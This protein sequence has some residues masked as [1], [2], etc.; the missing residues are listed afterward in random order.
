MLTFEELNGIVINT[1]LPKGQAKRHFSDIVPS[2]RD[3]GNEVVKAL[4]F[5]KKRPAE[6][7]PH[8]YVL[9]LPS[10]LLPGFEDRVIDYEDA[11]ARGHRPKDKKKI[12]PAEWEGKEKGPACKR[13]RFGKK[14][15]GVWSSYLKVKGWTE[16]KPV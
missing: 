14:C 10:C 11:V 13:C 1:V 7:F 8:I 4:S 12:L 6:N 15:A 16:F 5:L 3:V 9:G 2:Y